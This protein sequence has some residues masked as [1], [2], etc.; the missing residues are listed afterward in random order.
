MNL[1]TADFYS[2]APAYN[3]PVGNVYTDGVV[4][5]VNTIDANGDGDFVINKWP[6]FPVPE[7]SSMLAV[8]G[9]MTGLWACIR[10]R[11]A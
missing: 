8:L 5:W 9:G 10:R 7:P 6:S 3:I 4:F 11:K 1:D 2:T